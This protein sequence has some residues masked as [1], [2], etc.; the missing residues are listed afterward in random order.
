MSRGTPTVASQYIPGYRYDAHGMTQREFETK[1]AKA[2]PVEDG[3]IRDAE[4]AAKSIIVFNA[5]SNYVDISVARDEPLNPEFPN[6]RWNEKEVA[7]FP[8]PQ[9]RSSHVPLSPECYIITVGEYVLGQGGQRFFLS[10]KGFKLSEL[11]NV[12]VIVKSGQRSGKLEFIINANAEQEEFFTM[13]NNTTRPITARIVREATAYAPSPQELEEQLKSRK[14]DRGGN[15]IAEV[16]IL[17][18]AK[19]T[20]RQ[21]VLEYVVRA[22]QPFNDQAV[23]SNSTVYRATIAPTDDYVDQAMNKAT[24]GDTAIIFDTPNR[25]GSIEVVIYQSSELKFVNGDIVITK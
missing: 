18:K 23:K 17:P 15:L 16:T 19:W 6:A 10:D 14:P 13:R 21:P 24:I 11:E 2:I 25:D 20:F 1:Y 7:A 12:A 5:S 8:L 3:I 9:G 22:L 4:A